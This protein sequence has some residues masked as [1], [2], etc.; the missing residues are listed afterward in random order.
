MSYCWRN[1]SRRKGPTESWARTET[2]LLKLDFRKKAINL[3]GRWRKDT[4]NSQKRI[5]RELV[6]WW[7]E[8]DL[9]II[10]EKKIMLY[11]HQTG[12]V[13]QTLIS[14]IDDAMTSQWLHKCHLPQ[15]SWGPF[16]S[17]CEHFKCNSALIFLR[18]RSTEIFAQ[19]HTD[20]GTRMFI[21]PLFIV[22][23]VRN[24]ISVH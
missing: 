18:L 21:G 22:V 23:I 14:S 15:P 24:H 1:T 17:S 2:R 11:T 6:N 13:K 5:W 10:G 4:D 3:I 7:R 8:L 20:T 19:V 16:G 9:Y 12:K